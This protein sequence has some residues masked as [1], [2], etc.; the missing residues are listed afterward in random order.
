MSNENSADSGSS[1]VNNNKFSA[2]EILKGKNGQERHKGFVNRVQFWYSDTE[3]VVAIV[4]VLIVLGSINV[5]SSSFVMAE[6]DYGSPYFFLTRHLAIM[7]GSLVVAFLAYKFDYHKYGTYIPVIAIGLLVS[8]VLVLFIGEEING[9]KRWL[10][11]GSAKLQPA[12]FAKLCSIIIMAKTLEYRIKCGKKATMLSRMTIFLAIMAGLIIIEPDM[13]TAM[14]SIGIPIL[15]MGIVGLPRKELIVSIPSVAIAAAAFVSMEQYRI[16]RIMVWIDPFADA[17]NVGYQIVRSIIA[18]GSGG[19]WGM[20]LGEGVSK[21]YYLPEAH[22]DFA[23]AVF[24]QENGYMWVLFVFVLF[25]LL[26]YHMVRI[27]RSARDIYGHILS[28]G[29]MLLIV[30]QAVF[31]MLMVSG[32]FPV[33]GVPLPFISYGGSSLAVSLISIGILLNIAKQGDEMRQNKARKKREVEKAAKP[34]RKTLLRLIK[35]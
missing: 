9:A 23:F 2:E 29:I 15:M 10:G 19:W 6:S 11:Y 13:G 4:L 26:A 32:I 21:Y 22:T 28:M 1:E 33:I 3:A 14:I 20:G 25:G 5:F 18:I 31:N 30:G 27:A 24:S 16:D 7:A 17:Q 35:Q 34:R 12:E 8:L